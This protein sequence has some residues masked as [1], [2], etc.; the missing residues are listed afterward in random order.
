MVRDRPLRAVEFAAGA[1]SGCR[2]NGGSSK[3]S[4]QTQE[5]AADVLPQLKS[6]NIAEME[7]GETR[8]DDN[9]IKVLSFRDGVVFELQKFAPDSGTFRHQHLFR[10]LRYILE[11]RFVVNTHEYGPG[12]LIDFPENVPYE[13]WA[14]RRHLDRRAVAGRHDGRRADRP[15]RPR[16]REGPEVHPQSVMAAHV[17]RRNSPMKKHIC[18][19]LAAAIA[20]FAF[21]T[22]VAAQA[23]IEIKIADSFP[24]GHVIYDTVVSTLIP[25]L[26]EGGK[27]KVKYFPANQLGQM[28]DVIESIHGGVADIAS[29]PGHRRRPH[30]GDQPV[31]PGQF[32]SSE[33]LARVFM[34]MADGP[35][36][37]NTTSSGSRSSR[38]GAALPGVHAP[39]SSR[40]RPTPGASSCAAAA[41]T[42]TT[43]CATPAST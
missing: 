8:F 13:V 20:A 9:W 26:E 25:A 3:S 4:Q 21:A 38:V 40:C 32:T 29:G 11:G 23:P 42:P 14:R 43:S 31:L 22:E 30:A 28:A 37:V 18:G 5:Q 12:E 15:H 17:P 7:W 24:K 1:R 16:V 35:L 6:A 27:I 19:V 10:Q 39:R 33:H 36:K 2:Q 34:K 41:A